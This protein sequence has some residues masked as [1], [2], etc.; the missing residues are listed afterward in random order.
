[1]WLCVLTG[2]IGGVIDWS[3]VGP[4]AARDRVAAIFYLASALG[5][6]RQLGLNAWEAQMHHSMPYDWRVVV[7]L[8]SI[9]P[10]TLWLGAMCPELPILGKFGKQSF[11]GR[12]G[13]ASGGRMG[14][15]GP[16]S[17]DRINGRLLTMTVLLAASIPLAFP[18]TYASI[19]DWVGSI[20][21]SAA[22]AVAT[23]VAHFFGWR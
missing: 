11:R 9:V 5:W 6:F 14:P 16:S 10:F 4:N 15:S 2:V 8:S 22:L 20:A 21:T 12:S 17:G 7:S 1:M 23:V 3:G 13:G 18:S 19:L